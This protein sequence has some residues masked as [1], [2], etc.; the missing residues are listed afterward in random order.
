MVFVLSG[1][2]LFAYWVGDR[3]ASRR[4]GV[5]SSMCVI[6]GGLLTYSYLAMRLPGAIN[7]LQNN[8]WVG[9]MEMVIV[10]ALIGGAGAYMWFR[11]VRE[12][13]KQSG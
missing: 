7:Y 11:L 2:G 3:F 8:G 5:R 4:W 6:L 12:S 9:I 13:K 1:L 10:G